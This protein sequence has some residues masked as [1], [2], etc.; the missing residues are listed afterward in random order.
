M[1]GGVYPCLIFGHDNI[2]MT[3]IDNTKLMEEY[4]GD[5]SFYADCIN[6]SKVKFEF[7]KHIPT[8]EEIYEN[9]SHGTVAK[10]ADLNK[11]FPSKTKK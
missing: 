9:A 7:I 6:F 4:G 11:F 8:T 1:T 5:P 3:I 10:K 2:N